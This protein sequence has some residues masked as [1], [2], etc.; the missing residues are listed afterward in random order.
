LSTADPVN[1]A[2]YEECH[3]NPASV[4]L[5]EAHAAGTEVSLLILAGYIMAFNDKLFEELVVA[6]FI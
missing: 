6:A 3:I 1:G 4:D 5:I 2:V